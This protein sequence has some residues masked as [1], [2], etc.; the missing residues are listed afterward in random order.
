MTNSSYSKEGLN[1]LKFFSIP[2]YLEMPHSGI[3]IS[4]EHIR[5]M[6]LKKSK[7]G[8]IPL[9]YG[10]I[11][12][13][14][15]VIDGGEIQDKNTL[16]KILS[17]IRKDNNFK[18][19]KASLP[20][21]KAYFFETELPK[22]EDLNIKEAVGF[23]MEEN[24]PLAPNE[25]VYEY[26]IIP[27]QI[28]ESKKLLLNVYA[29]NKEVVNNYLELL[30]EAGY[31]PLSFEIESNASSKSF[32]PENLAKTFLVMSLGDTKTVLSIISSGLT[33]MTS[34]VGIGSDML[35]EAIRHSKNLSVAEAEKFLLTNNIRNDG[36]PNIIGALEEYMD[37]IKVGT[38]K[39]IQYWESFSENSTKNT[40]VDNIMIL[41]PNALMP[42]IRKEL[43]E[44]IEKNVDLVNVWKNCFSY[45]D[46]IPPIHFRDSLKYSTAIGLCL[47]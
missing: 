1:F 40:K 25:S 24:I 11:K 27:N 21:E 16:V 29:I 20:E 18:F 3:D 39:L 26:Q 28:V 22:V 41:G 43:T 33:R 45:D 19:I 12:I 46:Y 10:E 14:K 17:D 36:D 9:S 37:S 38:G 47:S 5:F 7:F 32:I 31:I 15:G 8:Q 35:I 2:K 13:P 6:S 4:D 30:L 34:T 42:G 44:K 23:K